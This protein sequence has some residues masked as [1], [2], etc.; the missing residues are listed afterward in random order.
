[1]TKRSIKKNKM[2]PRTEEQNKEIRN[3]KEELI[4]ITALDL[5]SH[6]GY[7]NTSVST[8]AKKAG[9]SKGLM[10]SY[11]DSKEQL[12]KKLMRD[13][14]TKMLD[15]YVVDE[16]GEV[17][18]KEF[19]QIIKGTFLALKKDTEFWKLYFSLMFQPD[20]MGMVMEE[21]GED[22]FSLIN[23]VQGYFENEGYEDPAGETMMFNATLDGFCL[24][25][26]AAPEFFQMEKLEAF[27]LKKY[28]V[29][30][31]LQNN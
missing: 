1:M 15:L 27:M 12:L 22:Q 17:G 9:I 30:E 23:K 18:K 28:N 8:I 2:S 21:F 19:A 10:Y 13:G 11:F 20:V 3:A 26:L 6:N 24:Q 25:Y 16:N 5:F 29:S 4:L 31:F 7:H 14:M